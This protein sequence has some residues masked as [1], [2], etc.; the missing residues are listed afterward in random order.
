MTSPV[1]A[2]TSV[3]FQPFRPHTTVCVFSRLS[4]K[5]SPGLQVNVTSVSSAVSPPYEPQSL[6]PSSR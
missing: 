3:W 4:A 6:V 2:L 5:A 1:Q